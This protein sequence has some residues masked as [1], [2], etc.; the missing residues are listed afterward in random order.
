MTVTQGA[1]MNAPVERERGRITARVSN[2]VAETLL[3]AAELTGSTLNQFVIS[4]HLNTRNVSSIAKERFFSP[5]KT[6]HYY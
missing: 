4:L 1:E 6:L 2:A 3:E 5:V